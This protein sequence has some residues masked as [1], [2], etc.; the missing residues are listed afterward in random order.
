MAFNPFEGGDLS[1]M[2]PSG[3]SVGAGGAMGTMAGPVPTPGLGSPAT[4][5]TTPLPG[6]LSDMFGGSE[7]PKPP[8]PAIDRLK[9]GSDLH[10]TVRGKLDAMLRFSKGKMSN[11]YNRWN[12][13]EQKVQAYTYLNDY[14]AVVNNLQQKGAS[15][16]EP[17]KVIVPYS[18]A[19]LHAAATFIATV[20]LG[21]K[22]I[23]P[24]LATRG[25]Q[26]DASRYMETAIQSQLD[27][28]RAYETLWQGIWDSLNYGF[29]PARITWEER[30]GQAIRWTGGRRELMTSTTFAGN[31]VSAVDPYSF[32]PDPRVP[33][34]QCNV[35]GD[36]MFSEMSISE[37]VLKDMARGNQLSWVEEGIKWVKSGQRNQ[38]VG[39]SNRRVRIGQGVSIENKPVNVTGFHLLAEGTVRLVPKEW[40]LGSEEDSALWK[41]SWFEGGQIMQ[42][43]P[44]GMIHNQHPYIA[45]E[46]TTFGHDFM[47]LSM[48]DMIGN[49][50]DILSWL[51]SSR[52]ENV[53]SSIQN[54][55]A[56]DPARIDVGDIRSSA[57]G[58]II[59]LKQTAM[60][61]PVKDA[62]MQL[63]VQDVTMGHLSDMQ[64]M[65]VLAD[66]ITGV[67]DNMRGIQT[68]GGRRS[69]TE[70]RI[71][72]QNGGGRL[73][74]HAVRISAQGY[75]PMVEQMISNTQQFM[76]D[77]MWAEVSGDE[78]QQSQ[79]L[80]PDMLCGSFNYQVSDGTLPFDKMALVEVWKEIMM[81]VAQDPELRQQFDIGKIFGE[82]AVL[83]GAKNIDAFRKQQ[84]P[85]MQAGAMAD[86]SQDPNLVPIGPAAP[87]GPL[88]LGSS[89]SG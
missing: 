21:R 50:Q 73:S 85:P 59:R 2:A 9:P 43:E 69:A 11:H 29:G 62:I 25:T 53:R 26:A 23:F 22:P 56:V 10:N 14:E 4:V 34:H 49:F 44:L 40:G 80:T 77:E 24:L 78:K 20:L 68:A 17:F 70:A 71:A 15:P 8:T 16:P 86:P 55:F 36:F 19:T 76:P 67:N 64:N 57:I 41:F 3:P 37:T 79:L 87:A 39:D 46:P 74:Q 6:A 75:H 31:V 27:A 33:I 12:L 88:M 38:V 82:T 81:G 30:T 52:M 32:F 45:P 66:T 60:G 54:S 5:P 72:M 61:M 84:Q 65:R 7:P 28:S 89:F 48:S 47:S 13:N 35:R 18:Y 63:M 58:R 1:A 83:G 42:A 51:V